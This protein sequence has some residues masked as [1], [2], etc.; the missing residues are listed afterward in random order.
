M[1]KELTSE[2]FWDHFWGNI[3]LPAKVNLNFKNDKVISDELI[4]FAK[5]TG[6]NQTS[7]E[8]GCAPGKW[9]I[10][11]AEH[12]GYIPSG[13]E[14]VNSAALATVKNLKKCNIEGRVWTEDFFK[15]QINEHF[16]LVSSFGFI[17]H[18]ENYSEVFLKHVDLAKTDGLIAIFIPRFRGINYFIQRLID[19]SM[20]R[21]YL[22]SHHLP[23]MELEVFDKLGKE[24]NLIIL[25]N[26]YVGGFEP[27][28]FPVG[29]VKNPLTKL[30]VRI[31]VKLC[32]IFFSSVNSRM[33][34]SFQVAIFKKVEH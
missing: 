10:F 33:T 3:E 2:S 14:Y 7:L 32:S 1:E 29:E 34:S 16:N 25:R 30:I 13:I 24:N 18:F 4:K 22:S 15:F 27:S 31:L 8:I 20:D 5:A 28:L 6:E 26:E 9:M 23:I 12:L 11:S 21:P 19:P 17:E